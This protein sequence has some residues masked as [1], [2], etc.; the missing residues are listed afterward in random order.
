VQVETITAIFAAILYIFKAINSVFEAIQRAIVHGPVAA[1]LAA[2]YNVLAMI[3]TVFKPVEIR[4]LL[5]HALAFQTVEPVIEPLQAFRWAGQSDGRS[6]KGCE[7][8]GCEFQHAI[9]HGLSHAGLNAAR[10]AIRRKK[11]NKFKHEQPFIRRDVNR[12]GA[13]EFQTGRIFWLAPCGQRVRR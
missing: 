11:C 13:D 1:V 9:L 12:T 5:D 8:D 4:A 6:K 10:R 7:S 2:V 3:D